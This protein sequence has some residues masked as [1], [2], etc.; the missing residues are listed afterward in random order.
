M[1]QIHA[2]VLNKTSHTL[3]GGTE[4]VTPRTEGS[5]TVSTHSLHKLMRKVCV[6]SA[7]AD[8][9]GGSCGAESDSACTSVVI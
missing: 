3:T 8:R 1:A 9:E 5:G 2:A 4:G 6:I 7:T